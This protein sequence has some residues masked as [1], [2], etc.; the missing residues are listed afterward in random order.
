VLTYWLPQVQ[1]WLSSASI[2]HQIPLN[3]QAVDLLYNTAIEA[4]RNEARLQLVAQG[5]RQKAEEYRTEGI[6]VFTWTI[7]I[8]LTICY[9]NNIWY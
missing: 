3:T 9:Q 8:Y 5:Y 6:L 1:Q 2:G 4:K 7:I